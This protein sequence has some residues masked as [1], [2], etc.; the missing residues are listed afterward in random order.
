MA[1]EHD[2]PPNRAELLRRHVTRT[3][4]HGTSLIADLQALAEAF[5]LLLPELA[6]ATASE[7][8]VEVAR[9]TG[10]DPAMPAHLA[11][12]V[13]TLA[14]VLAGLRSDDGGAAWL[15]HQ[16]ARLDAGEDAA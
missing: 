15:H 7:R 6:D 1:T 12:L 5:E 10:L 3:T 4:K 13:E 11:D 8:W 2:P 9:M 14:D 16:R